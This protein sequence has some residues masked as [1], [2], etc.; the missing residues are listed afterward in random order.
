M[1]I[2][3]KFFGAP[4]N[5]AKQQT[6]LSFASKPKKPVVE[7]E[8]EEEG[9]DDREVKVEEAKKGGEVVDTKENDVPEKGESSCAMDC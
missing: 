9:V 8:E 7:K 3:S 6:T 5:G 4:T 1:E 2:C